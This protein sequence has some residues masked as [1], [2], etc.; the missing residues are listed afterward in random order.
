LVKVDV[1]DVQG[2][3]QV[4]FFLK[5]F[6]HLG[7]ELGIEG[8]DLTGLAWCKVNDQKGYDGDKKES[9]GFLNNTATDK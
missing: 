5:P 3:V 6:N 4:K 2:L 8:I 7:S 9:D 1:L